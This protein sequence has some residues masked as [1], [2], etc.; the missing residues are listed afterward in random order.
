MN[1]RGEGG[2]ALT[3]VLV[4]GAI[5]AAVIVAAMGGLGLSTRGGNRADLARQDAF[6][7]RN[8]AARLRAGMRVS[9]ISD[10]YPDWQIDLSPYDRPV[11]PE[12]GAVLTQARLIR[13]HA[14]GVHYQLDFVYL[15]AG[16]HLQESGG[17]P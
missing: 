7:A 10:A 13:R 15:E 3:E 5:A 1:R 11:D 17:Q 9:Q 16:S 12:T 14:L 6:E 8:I 4:A 2:Y